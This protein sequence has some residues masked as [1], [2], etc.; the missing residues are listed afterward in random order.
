MEKQPVARKEFCVEW[1]IGKPNFRNACIHTKLEAGAPTV[2]IYD[3][4]V[5]NTIQS[6]NLNAL[7]D[8]LIGGFRHVNSIPF[9]QR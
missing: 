3:N 9:I 1:S 6:T 2:A 5:E 8:F 4:D 7:L